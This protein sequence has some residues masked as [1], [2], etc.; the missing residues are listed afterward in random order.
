MV[1]HPDE[2][3]TMIRIPVV[4]MGNFYSLSSTVLEDLQEGSAATF[5]L[6]IDGNPQ[7]IHTMMIHLDEMAYDN[8]GGTFTLNLDHETPRARTFIMDGDLWRRVLVGLK[9]HY[10]Y[11]G[12]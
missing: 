7:W 9:T 5:D 11:I 4:K 10:D 12:M 3:T 2:K 8:N 6:K 1:T